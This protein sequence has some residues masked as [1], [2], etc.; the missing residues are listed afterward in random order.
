MT[1]EY[2]WILMQWC[3]LALLTSNVIIVTR[4]DISRRIVLILRDLVDKRQEVADLSEVIP[5][6][7]AIIITEALLPVKT[8]DPRRIIIAISNLEAEE[9]LNI[10]DRSAE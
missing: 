6:D 3:I 4:K 1:E 8:Q 2:P 10:M 5:M 9:S 7:M